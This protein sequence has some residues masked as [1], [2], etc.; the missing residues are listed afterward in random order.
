MS[1]SITYDEKFKEL[2][3]KEEKE[4]E[5][6]KKELSKMKSIK[7][8]V[9]MLSSRV[10]ID[11]LAKRPLYRGDFLRQPRLDDEEEYVNEFGEK[12]FKRRKKRQR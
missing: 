4:Q 2:D 6:L 7:A 3:E 5:K 12:R 1:T 10:A 8:R 11:Q 9:L